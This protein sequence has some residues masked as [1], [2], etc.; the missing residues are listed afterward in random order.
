MYCY[1]CSHRYASS[2]NDG[3]LIYKCRLMDREVSMY[4]SCNKFERKTTPED[5]GY[6][7]PNSS[8]GCFL[9]SACVDY[10]G[11]ADDCEELTI[12]R[13]FRDDYMKTTERIH[14]VEEYYATAPLIVE[15]INKSPNKEKYYQE[16]FSTIIKCLSLIRE[17]KNEE[18][19]QEYQTMVLKL[20][21]EFKL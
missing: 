8:G 12:L 20:K 6:H 15:E 16:I 10:M 2:D 17:N 3:L 4:G 13:D 14:L 5:L 1:E 21:N 18:T 9:T 19:L 7:E 11:K